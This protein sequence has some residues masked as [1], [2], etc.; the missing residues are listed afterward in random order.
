MIKVCPDIIIKKAKKEYICNK[1]NKK[2]EK[3]NFYVNI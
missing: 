1:C 2:I 3:R